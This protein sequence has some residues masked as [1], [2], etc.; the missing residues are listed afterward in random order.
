M[1]V[2]LL[3]GDIG[4][5]KT[6]LAIFSSEAGPR[7]PLA[8]ATYHSANYPG[9]DTV[10]REFLTNTRVTVDRACF[11]V[12]GPVLAG[13]ATITN[14]PWV[15]DETHLQAALRLSSVRLLNDLEAVAYAVP[16][17]ELADLDTLQAGERVRGGAIAIIAPGTGLGEAFLTWEG[18][19]YRAHPSEGGHTDFA[20][21]N[22][23][24]LDLLRFLQQRYDHVSYERVCSGLGL[25]NIY[26]HLK[27]RGVAEEPPWLTA[28][29]QSADDPTPVIISAA[30]GNVSCD[31]CVRT[32]QTFVSILGAEAGNLALKVLATGGVYV[33][34]G[35][36]PR[37][38]PALES[39][40]FIQAFIQKGRQ[41]ALLSRVPVHVI[42]NPKVGLLG[43]ARYGLET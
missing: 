17:L 24:E 19:R 40:S 27:A 34:G 20:P 5:T 41:A 3:A 28:Q 14:L 35:I 1:M 10:A 16:S 43:A 23:L 21:A 30:L 13:R 12:A 39:G 25:P 33:G 9:L 36:P 4:G 7:A 22:E 37:I 26:A 8:E 38:V 42:L 15:M 11:G 18:S 2:R 31:L 32:L 29:L 6:A